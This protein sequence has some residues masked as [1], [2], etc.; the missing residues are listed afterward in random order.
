MAFPKVGSERRQFRVSRVR[1]CR[2]TCPK[3]AVWTTPA[4][5]SRIPSSDQPALLGPKCT[6]VRRVKQRA[7]TDSLNVC[8]VE[9]S[10]RT[11]SADRPDHQLLRRCRRLQLGHRLRRN[12]RILLG[13]QRKKRGLVRRLAVGEAVILLHPSLPLVDILTGM[14]REC[15]P[16]DRSLA[17]G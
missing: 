16:N 13:S 4:A 6:R 17:D 3:I 2:G 11:S 1:E 12:H 14:Q 9:V 10:G 8:P 15:Q 7:A 5:R